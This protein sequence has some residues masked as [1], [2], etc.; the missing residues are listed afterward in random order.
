[1]VI[2][3][4]IGTVDVLTS[5]PIRVMGVK[6]PGGVTRGSVVVFLPGASYQV[7]DLVP[8]QNWHGAY[9]LAAS[10]WQLVVSD[11]VDAMLTTPNC[12]TGRCAFVDWLVVGPTGVVARSH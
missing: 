6:L 8:R 7:S 10:Q 4:E 2:S 5:G 3:P 11:R 1:M 9:R 12:T